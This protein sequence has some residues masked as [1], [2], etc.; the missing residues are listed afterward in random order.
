MLQDHFFSTRTTPNPGDPDLARLGSAGR[1]AARSL[2]LAGP[3]RHT[4]VR[5]K[6]DFQK[7]DHDLQTLFK[8]TS[9][10]TPDAKWLVEN[11]RLV[12]TAVKEARNLP[13]AVVEYR[14]AIE[15]TQTA[16]VALPAAVTRAYFSAAMD[17]FSQEGFISFL[18]G[19]QEVHVLEMGEL[20]ALKP[21]LQFAAVERIAVAGNTGAHS[22]IPALITSL[23][24]IG[25]TDWKETFELLSVTNAVLSR[26]PSGHFARMDYQSRD[27][28]RNVI[29]DLA[30]RSGLREQETAE[31]AIR[32]ASEAESPRARHVG[33]WLLDNGLSVLR[34]EIGYRPTA[35]QRARDFVRRWSQSWYLIGI[36]VLT[37][38]IAF[39]ILE[40]RGT[41]TPT[42]VALALLILPV[43]QAAV[44]FINNL[45]SHLLAPRIL[46][47]LDFSRGIPADCATL[48]AVPTL[49]LNPKQVRQLVTDLE[50]RYLANRMPACGLLCS[51]MDLIPT[52]PTTNETTSSTSAPI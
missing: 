48:V 3:D 35:G 50:I 47:K 9:L 1:Q 34:T 12:C 25:E 46:P 26:D 51:P 39:L 11:Y 42:L 30:E 13:T 6:R 20:W 33:Y 36:E 5:L 14:T 27:L 16:A 23:R 29:A 17:L 32:L 19:F 52:H 38:A 2:R 41:F 21:A 49:L 24:L 18:Q 40:G 8:S 4:S 43:T 45:T 37:L 44:D 28:Y 7:A 31:T 15:E 10:R 22:S